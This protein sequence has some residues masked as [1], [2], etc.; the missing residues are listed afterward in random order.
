MH[1]DVGTV[2][3]AE[4]DEAFRVER[5][6]KATSESK[7]LSVITTSGA[8]VTL[9][10]GLVAV[11]TGKNERP[12]GGAAAGFLFA[13][14]AFFA[15]ASMLGIYCNA[16]GR[17]LEIDPG[18]LTSMTTPEVWS[19]DA[20]EA[21]R[22]LALAHIRILQNWRQV[23]LSRARVLLAAISLEVA[24]VAAVAVAAVLV[25]AKGIL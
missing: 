23:N 12:T 6:K 24:G 7:G 22:E 15:A 19:K 3:G 2:L 25:V 17:Y 21:Q 18:S 13:G 4:L 11:A 1:D 16:P 8:L 14:I 5:A 9:L 10:F 20:A